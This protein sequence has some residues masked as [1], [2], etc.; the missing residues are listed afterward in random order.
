VF[1][2]TANA[3]LSFEVCW[4]FPSA[5]IDCLFNGVSTISFAV[6]QVLRRIQLGKE[7]GEVESILFCLCVLYTMHS[8]EK[9]Y[10][11]QGTG[12]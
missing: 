12:K 9:R 7:M 8:T 1:M 11:L 2:S 4:I 6:L 10:L 3:E 5:T